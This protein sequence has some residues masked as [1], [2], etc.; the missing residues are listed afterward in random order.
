MAIGALRP[1]THD[2]S[3]RSGRPNVW[4]LCRWL[5]N[6]AVTPSIGRP[7]A[8]TR[9][10]T[11]APA[12]NRNT[13]RPTTTAVAGPD[14]SG[15]GT[16]VPVPNVMTIA[17]SENGNA[18]PPGNTRCPCNGAEMNAAMS[19]TRM[20]MR[21]RRGP[22]LARL[23]VCPITRLSGVLHPK[24]VQRRRRAPIPLRH[25]PVPHVPQVVHAHLARPEAGR[26]E[27]P[28]VVEE[29]DAGLHLR[30]RATRPRDVVEHR[31][32]LCIVARDERL[33][34]PL[35]RFFV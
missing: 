19:K 22:S 24:L 29:P 33:R 18:G 10:I 11:P 4:S 28:E 26:G 32:A 2:V 14:R 31:L 30:P 9:R 25:R 34:E 1:I 12:S 23:P 6:A 21:S 35:L 20:N 13:R 8:A 3:M 17:E 7:A 27:V 16:G 15:L 5:M